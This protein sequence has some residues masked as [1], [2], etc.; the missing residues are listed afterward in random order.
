M[1]FKANKLLLN[2]VREVFVSEVNDVYICS[3]KKDFN[4]QYY[5]LLIIKDH[6]IAGRIIQSFEINKKQNKEPVYIDCFSIQDDTGMVFP[7]YFERPLKKFYMGGLLSVSECEEICSNLL[8][9][10]VRLELPPELLYLILSQEA[11][12]IQRDNS[13]SFSYMLNLSEYDDKRTEKDCVGKCAEIIVKLLEQ[14]HKK[15]IKSYELIR[16]KTY[17][18]GYS[19]FSELYKDIML[20]AASE[21]KRDIRIQWKI[22]WEGKRDGLFR[23]LLIIC[24]VLMILMLIMLLSQII[25]GE[26]PLFRLCSNPFKKIGTETLIK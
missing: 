20:A 17:K 23:L 10:C 7:Y 16:K 15:N 24:I 2:V 8:I 9:Q 22:F 11:I 13:I 19:G 21:H 4:N 3:D 25:F 6:R 14:C 18:N 26:V 1:V 12:H 5:T